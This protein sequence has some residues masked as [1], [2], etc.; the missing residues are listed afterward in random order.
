MNVGLEFNHS[1]RKTLSEMLEPE[2]LVWGGIDVGSYWCGEELMWGGIGVGRWCGEVLNLNEISASTSTIDIHKLLLMAKG[3]S[4]VE[5]SFAE[6]AL[7]S[8]E[9][10]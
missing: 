2:V 10:V 8:W 1:S 9:V 6:L 4:S 3:T 5:S 7:K